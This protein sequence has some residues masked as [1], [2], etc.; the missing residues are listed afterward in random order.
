[1]NNEV[2]PSA[3]GSSSVMAGREGLLASM[4]EQKNVLDE[5][6]R[7]LM[8]EVHAIDEDLKAYNKAIAALDPQ[9]AEGSKVSKAALDKVR[10]TASK[11]GPERLAEITEVIRDLASKDPDG[12]IRQVDVTH[13]TGY[14]S[15]VMSAAFNQLRD[16]NVLRIARVARSA[17][18][19]G[20]GKGTWFRL[21]RPA[22]RDGQPQ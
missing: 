16:E 2:T 7:E 14:S 3:N 9:P 12:E 1:M 18:D 13:V 17:T 6:R 20:K 21:T 15:A 22:L 4:R 10:P 19:D 8:V 11:V 5:R